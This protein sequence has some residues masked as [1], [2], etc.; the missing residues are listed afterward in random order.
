MRL[1][2]RIRNPIIR[3]RKNTDIHTRPRRPKQI[4]NPPRA[5]MMRRK[6]SFR[7]IAHDCRRDRQRRQRFDHFLQPI[8]RRIMRQRLAGDRFIRQ[9]KR[10]ALIQCPLIQIRPRRL[11]P[12][13]NLLALQ[14]TQLPIHNAQTQSFLNILIAHG[15]RL[16]SR[17]RI[18]KR[19]THSPS[20]PSSSALV[21]CIRLDFMTTGSFI[22][23]RNKDNFCGHN[24]SKTLVC[25][26][27]RLR[28]GGF[29]F[30]RDRR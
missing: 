21:F 27:P 4:H 6:Q 28:V 8:Q 20:P 3:N 1:D 2:H 17:A 26:E 29:N 10:H 9:I 15:K 12:P 24:Y 11:H 14:P 30:F 5:I 13:P 19:Y 16:N 18:V 25:V 23:R 22:L 7:H